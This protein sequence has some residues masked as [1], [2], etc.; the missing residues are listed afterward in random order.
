MFPEFIVIHFLKSFVFGRL[1][2]MVG[3]GLL[4]YKI[5]GA[6]TRVCLFIGGL[7]VPLVFNEDI[8]L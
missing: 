1:S 7:R 5:H 6:V 3:G 2:Q 8:F 4:Q